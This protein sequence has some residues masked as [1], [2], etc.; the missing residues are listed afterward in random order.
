MGDNTKQGLVIWG[1]PEVKR[2]VL[3]FAK[4][5]CAYNPFPNHIAMLGKNIVDFWK[6]NFKKP[7]EQVVYY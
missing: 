1:R 5:K 6:Q 2:K 7:I 3:I 4:L